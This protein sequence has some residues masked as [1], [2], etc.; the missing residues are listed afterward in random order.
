TEIYIVDKRMRPLPP[1]IP[2]ELLIGGSGVS[3]GY[4]DRPELTAEKFVADPF[5]SR[6]DGRLYRTGDLARW[7]RDGRLEVVG[8]IDH[9]VKLRGYRIELGEIE[10]TLGAHP[11]VRQAVV[12]VREDRPGDKRLVAYLTRADGVAEIDL[13]S[14][15][16]QARQRLPEY[17]MPSAI[18]TL[19]AMPLTPNGKVDRRALPAPDA[20]ETAV[21]AYVAPRNAEEETLATLWGDILG[22]PKIGIHDNF[23]DLGGHSLL[24]TQLVARMQK[25]M[26][27][28]ITLRMLFEAPTI[29][30]FADLLLRQRMQSVDADALAGIL[31]ELEGLSEE[32]IQNLLAS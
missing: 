4:L 12:I 23:F 26:G 5:G 1:G 21:D 29:A 27:G 2:G 24:A 17:M 15:R 25:T 30:E 28:D 9:Q 32:D 10:S 18:V 20:E 13:P 16:A 8:R 11:Q 31:Q 14:L 3:Q 7:R 6:P 19:D 22:R